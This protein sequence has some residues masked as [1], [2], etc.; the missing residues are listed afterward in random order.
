MEI[1]LFLIILVIFQRIFEL[2]IAKRNERRMKQLGAY[3]LGASHYP[4][5]ILLHAGFFA[6]LMVEVIIFERTLSPFFVYLFVFFMLV[7]LL[8]I[9][10][11]LSLGM[12]WNTKII[13]L[14]GTKPVKTGPYAFFKHPNY[15]VVCCEIIIMPIMF[16]A[17]VT[18]F[19]FSIL[20]FIMLS[21][22]IPLEEKA[23]SEAANG[24][25]VLDK[26]IQHP[27]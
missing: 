10:C 12:Y 19:I 17:Y 9:W 3:E 16:Q 11:I 14:P 4:F 13:V 2:I 23:L 27:S 8:R 5:M 18:A 26:K 20:N 1:F 15:F 7:Q 6:S 21:I 22:R 25:Y 24:E